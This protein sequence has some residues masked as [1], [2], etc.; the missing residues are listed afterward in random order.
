MA[1]ES[2]R[3]KVKGRK[4]EIHFASALFEGHATFGCQL[5]QVYLCLVCPPNLSLTL[6]RTSGLRPAVE[7]FAVNRHDESYD[8]AQ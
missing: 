8:H 5:R 3:V 7:A 6:S 1:V 2:R 4:I